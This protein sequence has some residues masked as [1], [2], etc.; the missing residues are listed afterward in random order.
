MRKVP[1]PHPGEILMQEFAL[2]WNAMQENRVAS[3]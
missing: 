3:S 2:M 1:Y